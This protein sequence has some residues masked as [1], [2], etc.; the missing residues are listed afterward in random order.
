MIL[1]EDEMNAYGR[2]LGRSLVPGTVIALVGDLGA[3]KTTLSKA[4]AEGLGVTECV[5]SPTFTIL[6]EYRTGRLP[7]FHFDVYRLDDPEEMENIGYEDYFYGNGVTIVEWADKIEEL[8]PKDAIVIRID[9]GKNPWERSLT[10][11]SIA[12]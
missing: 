11:P 2:K 8:L 10:A 1:N 12:E 9:S 3:G 7:L 6:C 5:T 4:I